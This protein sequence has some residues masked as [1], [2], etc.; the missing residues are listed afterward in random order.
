MPESGFRKA[1]DLILREIAVTLARVDEHQVR[2]LEKAIASDG[3]VFVAGE[4]R[5]GL[6]ARCFAMRL[7]HLGVT[8]H[9]VGETVTP[10]FRPGDL[11]V[12]VSGS[13]E[14]P[15]TCSL[16]S[17]AASRG[18]R[19]VA[20]TAGAQSSLAQ[21]AHAVLSI[22]ASESAQFGGTLFEQSA[23]IALDAVAWQLQRRLRQTAEQ[24]Q[25]RHTTLE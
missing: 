3:A 25:A 18:G 11:L 10:A 23:L 22:P 14:T 4:G 1:S 13:G 12:A 21:A 15:V 8:A 17:S 20:V 2:A 7:M 16:A 5:S 19:V 9:V 24:M 6:V